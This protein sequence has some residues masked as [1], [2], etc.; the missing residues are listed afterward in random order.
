[1]LGVVPGL[2]GVLQATEAI[3]WIARIG[4]NLAGRLLTLDAMSMQMTTLT[5]AADPRCN[6]CAARVL[7]RQ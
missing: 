1:M 2:V 3:K 7:G 5:L 4:D 6:T